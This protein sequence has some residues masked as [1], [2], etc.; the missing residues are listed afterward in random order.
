MNL[1]CK[2][3]TSVSREDCTAVCACYNFKIVKNVFRKGLFFIFV[4]T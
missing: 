1:K 4:N 3:E 2:D